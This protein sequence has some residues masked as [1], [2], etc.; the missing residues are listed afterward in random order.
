VPCELIDHQTSSLL[1][2]VIYLLRRITDTCRRLR[3]EVLETFGLTGTPSYGHLKKM[4][5]RAFLLLRTLP[6]PTTPVYTHSTRGAQGDSPHLP[7][8]PTHSA[9]I[10]RRTAR[11][12][13]HKQALP[14]TQ[15]TNNDVL[16][17]RT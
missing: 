12:P 5:Y 3:E 6:S 17:P 4:E 11:H 14:P 1:T 8:R 10:Y 16:P 15:D 9:H 13:K 2:F 7:V